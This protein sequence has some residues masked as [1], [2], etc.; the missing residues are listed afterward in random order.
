[1]LNTSSNPWP[2]GK[3][4]IDIVGPFIPGIGQRRYLIVATDYFTKWAEVKA[5]QHIRDKDIF[6][7]IFENI[8]CRFGIPSHLVSDNGKQFEGENIEMLLNAFKIQSGK[9]TPLY[10]Q[11]N[12]QNNKERSNRN[13]TFLFDIWGKSSVTNRGHYPYNKERSL[14]EESKCGFNLTKLDD[15]E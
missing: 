15:L 3:W 2:F 6:T 4:G 11:S 9:S 5:V 14:G 7:F 8:I 13:V 10:P 12:G 1:M